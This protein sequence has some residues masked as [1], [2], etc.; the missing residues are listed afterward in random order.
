MGWGTTTCRYGCVCVPYASEPALLDSAMRFLLASLA[1][2]SNSFCSRFAFSSGVS[3]F[4]FLSFLFFFLPFFFVEEAEDDSEDDG[5]VEEEE[6]VFFLLL[7]FFDF[8]FDFFD[9]FFFFLS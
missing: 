7:D 8:F 6:L 4:S 9:F 3:V 5:T 2:P 1:F